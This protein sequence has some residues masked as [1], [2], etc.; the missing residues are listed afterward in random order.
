M[1]SISMKSSVVAALVVEEQHAP[2]WPPG[3]KTHAT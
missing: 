3:Y 2:V 1:N